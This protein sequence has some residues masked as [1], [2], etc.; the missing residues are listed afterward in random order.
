MLN[1]KILLAGAIGIVFLIVIS[2]LALLFSRDSSY[3]RVSVEVAEP[4]SH[5]EFEAQ[6][7]K[8]DA[9]LTQNDPRAS[10]DYLRTTIKDDPVV[11]RVCHPLLHHLGHSAYEKYK[12]FNTAVN[13]QD[14]LCNSGYIHGVI[15]AHFM[16]S[17]D[18]NVALQTTCP[19]QESKQ[20]FQ[21]WQCNHGMGHGAMYYT[22]KDLPQSLSLCETLATKQARNSCINGAFM[23]RFI[24]VSHSGTHTS[25]TSN[26][27]ID[28]CKQQ[29]DK[30]KS[31]CYIYAPTAY[32]ERH[33]NEYDGAFDDCDNADSGYVGTC[34]YGVGG[35]AMKENVTRPEVARDVCKNAPR[36]FV[37]SCIAGAIGVLI[38][39]HATTLPVQ[40]LCQTTF[41][42]F[43]D[44]CNA[45]IK[46][47]N[48]SY[49]T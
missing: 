35:Q 1:K 14:G 36:K 7:T 11:A 34:I 31:D 38:N 12:D 45:K 9:L 28:L 5:H 6:T 27:T 18:I 24:I 39:H 30:Y 42:E 32:L 2:L 23:E 40:P 17:D 48:D 22:G 26:V 49:A 20:T 16:V 15:E 21:Q 8:L 41:S 4:I 13:Y 37:S 25:D 19:T 3:D 43:K 29:A 10:F 44:T 33:P 47:W 46:V